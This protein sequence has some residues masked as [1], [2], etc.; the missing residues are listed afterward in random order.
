MKSAWPPKM[1]RRG[2][3][4]SGLPKISIIKDHTCIFIPWQQKFS[5]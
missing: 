3:M 1:G 5:S 2:L 4:L